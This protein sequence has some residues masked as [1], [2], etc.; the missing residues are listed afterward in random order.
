MWEMWFIHFS[1][2]KKAYTVLNNLAA[3]NGDVAS[4]MSIN[5]REVGLHYPSKGPE[6]LCK[7]LSAWNTSYDS[8]VPEK[9]I[10]FDWHGNQVND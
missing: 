4:C 9:P 1:T 6:N 2:R 5:R 7:L 10:K 8:M 3:V